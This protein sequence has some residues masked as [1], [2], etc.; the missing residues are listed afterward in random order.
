M[1]SI[2]FYFRGLDQA[3]TNALRQ[4]LNDI[5]AGLGYIAHAGPTAGAGNLADLLVAIDSGE[6]AP[7]LLPDEQ[8][9]QAIQYLD[10]LGEEWAITISIAL[11]A[12]SNRQNNDRPEYYDDQT[13][14]IFV[15]K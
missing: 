14:T 2:G 15:V 1:T 10:S 9:L 12:A 4:R 5:A 7:V 8:R 11:A 6:V 13:Q 3:K